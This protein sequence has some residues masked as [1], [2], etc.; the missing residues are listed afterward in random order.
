MRYVKKP[1]RCSKCLQPIH[2]KRTVQVKVVLKSEGNKSRTRSAI[3]SKP[4]LCLECYDAFII[5]L[6]NHIKEYMNAKE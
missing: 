3:R 2:M 6:D 1:Y 5:S 4:E